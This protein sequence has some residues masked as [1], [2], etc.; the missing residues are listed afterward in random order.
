MV[1]LKSR[2]RHEGEGRNFPA[3]MQVTQLWGKGFS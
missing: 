3:R 2:S 1:I